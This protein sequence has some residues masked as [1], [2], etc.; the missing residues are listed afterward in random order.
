LSD[1]RK[2]SAAVAPPVTASS[3]VSRIEREG[4]TCADARGGDFDGIDTSSNAV[5]NL[6]DGGID[7]GGAATVALGVRCW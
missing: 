1:L 2:S 6:P 7:T 3:S 5:G 4:P